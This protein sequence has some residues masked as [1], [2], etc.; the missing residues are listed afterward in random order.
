MLIFQ[1]QSHFPFVSF[2]LYPSRVR[3]RPPHFFDMMA[4]G[5][6]GEAMNE[7]GYHRFTGTSPFNSPITCDTNLQDS[8]QLRYFSGREQLSGRACYTP[9]YRENFWQRPKPVFRPP[10]QRPPNNVRDH[11]NNSYSLR[12]CTMYNC[13]HDNNSM[14]APYYYNTFYRPNDGTVNHFNVNAMPSVLRSC[15]V[16][17]CRSPFEQPYNDTMV[18]R[19]SGVWR[20]TYLSNHVPVAAPLHR[21]DI[22]LD[23][24]PDEVRNF[25]LSREEVQICAIPPSGT[26]SSHVGYPG[27]LGG[28]TF[29]YVCA[30][31]VHGARCA[32]KVSRGLGRTS[33]D[34]HDPQF[35]RE[36]MT[37]SKLRSNPNI[38]TLLG[39]VPSDAMSDSC[40]LVMEEMATSLQSVIEGVG[41]LP[42]KEIL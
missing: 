36:V 31:F 2:F 24:L 27:Y 42:R 12:N 28:G 40:L 41:P 20:N 5:P 35:I 9:S 25:R 14:Y 23:T 7:E 6:H 16:E 37:L 8:P 13:N 1:L 21:E 29:G 38:V 4:T 34:G 10:G 22:L 39:F 26:S 3:R 15:R 33:A 30:G 32:V 18:T 11:T 19:D 17:A